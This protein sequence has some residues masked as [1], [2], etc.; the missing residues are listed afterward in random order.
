MRQRCCSTAGLLHQVQLGGTSGWYILYIRPIAANI[1]AKKSHRGDIPSFESSGTPVG[2]EPAA[3]GLEVLALDPTSLV[4]NQNLR[5]V[6]ER[7]R[8]ARIR[9]S[10]PT[11]Y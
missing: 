11:G 4:V 3:L 7:A 2:F 8:C 10:C 6:G 5:E 1:H 9:V